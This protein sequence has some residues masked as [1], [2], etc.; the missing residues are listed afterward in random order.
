[1]AD[2]PGNTRRHRG[3]LPRR[4]RCHRRDRRM[5]VYVD[6]AR[7]PARVGR[8]SARWSHLTADTPGEL[9]AFAVRIGLRRSWFQTC[10]NPPMCPPERCPHWHYD[11]TD[12]KRREAL[13]AGAQPIDLYRLAAIIA[14]RRA[15]RAAAGRAAEQTEREIQAAIAGGFRDEGVPL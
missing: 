12:T 3:R 8:L 7:I 5:S 11:V 9:H 15:E 2:R 14:D 10:K 6:N 1:Q 4:T 13:N